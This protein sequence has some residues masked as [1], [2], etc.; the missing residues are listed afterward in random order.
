MKQLRTMLL[1]A[2]AASW[3]VR[4]VSRCDAGKRAQTAPS[5]SSSDMRTPLVSCLLQT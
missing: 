4:L 2:A 5:I 1:H 3:S